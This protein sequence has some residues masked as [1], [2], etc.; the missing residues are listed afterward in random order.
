MKTASG[1]F[2]GQSQAFFDT[3]NSLAQPA[4]AAVRQC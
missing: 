2:I 1:L 3:L 4:D